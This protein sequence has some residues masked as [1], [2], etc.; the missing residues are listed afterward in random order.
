MVSKLGEDDVL[1]RFLDRQ[2][3]QTTSELGDSMKQLLTPRPFGP[4]ATV[5]EI[6]KEALKGHDNIVNA[7]PPS[8]ESWLHLTRDESYAEI[9]NETLK[10]L[11]P[12]AGRDG[13]TMPPIECGTS[14]PGRSGALPMQPEGA[15][16][17]RCG[18]Q[19]TDSEC[20]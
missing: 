18:T 11:P 8:R 19:A 9:T 16:S 20:R 13:L 14:C 10:V 4:T 6:V 15:L 7:N 3:L 5:R 1:L 17:G 2:C 12:R